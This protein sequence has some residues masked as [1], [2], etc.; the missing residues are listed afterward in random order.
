MVLEAVREIDPLAAPDEEVFDFEPG[1]PIR[2]RFELPSRLFGALRRRMF[3]WRERM[4]SELPRDIPKRQPWVAGMLS[5]LPGLGQLYN[6]QPKKA[7]LILL[8]VSAVFALAAA[9]FYH[10]F[11]N[12]VLVGYLLAVVYAFHD[13]FVT[14]KHI[15]EDFLPIQ[16]AIA[17]YCAW[18][19]YIAF[20]CLAVQFMGRHFLVTFRYL[21]HDEMSPFLR[22]G[23]KIV[24]DK[25][26]YLWREP[27]VGEVVFYNP[28][29][30]KMEKLGTLIPFAIPIDPRNAI[31]RVVAGPGQTFERRDGVFYRDGQPVP[32]A[33]QPIVQEQIPRNF[34]LQAPENQFVVLFTY[35][36]ESFD[37]TNAILGGGLRA[38]APKLN[39]PGWALNYWDKACI[40]DKSDIFGR[41][42]CVY[43]PPPDRRRI[44]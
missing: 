21:F 18:I 38:R 22:R 4:Y 1:T 24:V 44:R 36:G 14:A 16:H 25:W 15:N 20:F 10:P 32:P 43:Q 26:T 28:G 34:K 2:D 9:T 30:I 7:A 19:F 8:F 29:T 40:I 37:E 13:G 23:E 39:E 17:Y 11:S 31:E 41:V 6:H 5:I 3:I 35:T 27:R 33:E 12:W 42:I